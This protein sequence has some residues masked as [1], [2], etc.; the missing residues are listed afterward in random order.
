MP[1][2][3]PPSVVEPISEHVEVASPPAVSRTG[4]IVKPRARFQEFAT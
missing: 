2:T 3:D 4:R 1:Q